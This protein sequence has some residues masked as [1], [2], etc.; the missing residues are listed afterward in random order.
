[1]QFKSTKYFNLKIINFSNHCQY[2]IVPLAKHT[3][4]CLLFYCKIPFYLITHLKIIFP[5]ENSYFFFHFHLKYLHVLKRYKLPCTPL[6]FTFNT[7]NVISTS[8]S[9][10]FLYPFSI[11]RINFLPLPETSIYNTDRILC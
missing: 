11:F 7:R 1:M 8:P 4:D 5:I 3:S 6:M 9:V 2:H 10:E